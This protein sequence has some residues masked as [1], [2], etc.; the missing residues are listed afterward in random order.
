[1]LGD[2]DE[3]TSE[4]RLD[5]IAAAAYDA[6]PDVLAQWLA[7][8]D[9]E[10]VKAYMKKG[11]G[12]L[13]HYALGNE[14]SDHYQDRAKNRD[15]VILELVRLG[16]DLNAP[17]YKGETPSSIIFDKAHNREELILELVRLGVNLAAADY[18]GATPISKIFQYAGYELLTKILDV[19]IEEEIELPKTTLFEFLRIL[20]TNLQFDLSARFNHLKITEKLF[21]L[22]LDPNAPSLDGKRCGTLLHHL[23]VCFVFKEGVNERIKVMQLIEL[24]LV[25]GA[26]PMLVAEESQKSVFEITEES[27]LYKIHRLINIHLEAPSALAELNREWQIELSDDLYINGN[28]QKLVQPKMQKTL[29]FVYKYSSY[30]SEE[31]LSTVIE[32]LNPIISSHSKEVFTFFTKLLKHLKGTTPRQLVAKAITD[33]FARVPLTDRKVAKQLYLANIDLQGLDYMDAKKPYFAWKVGYIDFLLEEI[34]K[35]DDVSEIYKTYEEIVFLL[36]S[37]PMRQVKT[38]A[39]ISHIRVTSRQIIASGD[40]EQRQQ[41]LNHLMGFFRLS[42]KN[43]ALILADEFSVFELDIYD[44]NCAELQLN[45]IYSFAI[46]LLLPIDPTQI[47]QNILTVLKRGPVFEELYQNLID[48]QTLSE[49][50][51]ALFAFINSYGRLHLKGPMTLEY[52]WL[53][54][55]S[56]MLAKI[57][58]LTKIHSNLQLWHIAKEDPQ[59]QAEARLAAAKIPSAPPIEESE[60]NLFISDR[61]VEWDNFL[62]GLLEQLGIDHSKINDVDLL[63][64]IFQADPLPDAESVKNKLMK[65][66][67]RLTCPVTEQI[68]T[69]PASLVAVNGDEVPSYENAFLEKWCDQHKD[70]DGLQ[71]PSTRVLVQPRIS[72]SADVRRSFNRDFKTLKQTIADYVECIKTQKMMALTQSPYPDLNFQPPQAIVGQAP[73]AEV[74]QLIADDLPRSPYSALQQFGFFEEQES[75][76]SPSEDEAIIDIL[77]N[78]T[79]HAG[80]EEDKPSAPLLG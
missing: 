78:L 43:H 73:T 68:I 52:P 51:T 20:L 14:L 27:S 64:A 75:H 56:S 10:D 63:D 33:F 77:K 41:V 26:D 74:P 67:Q 60:E 9:V 66:I 8:A 31:V 18:M 55:V 28:Y 1:M 79:V 34:N 38:N 5:Y 65:I 53:Q 42:L 50:K 47:K 76:S 72:R 6:K 16:V 57:Y 22:G 58:D 69:K 3:I 44:E 80:A 13:L 62:R 30:M 46:S 17:N 39:L 45:L 2:H 11:Y 29:N 37:D 71:D 15:K 25:R 19:C 54:D 7:D 48:A 12:N 4:R 70:E 36:E 59:L 49:L 32:A 61:Q 23:V 21:Q 35:M 40:K 24:F